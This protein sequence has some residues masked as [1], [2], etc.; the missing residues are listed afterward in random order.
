MT[1][2]DDIKVRF[3]KDYD[4]PDAAQG[5]SINWT[6]QCPRHDGCTKVRYVNAAS[7]AHHGAVEPLAFLHAW[8]PCDPPE[9]SDKSHRVGAKPSQAAVDAVVAARRAE[10]QAVVDLCGA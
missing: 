2:L 5:Q 7:T 6:L 8:A 1:S 4:L 3:E 9:G 10:L